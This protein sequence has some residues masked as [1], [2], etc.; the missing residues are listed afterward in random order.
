[1]I[2]TQPGRRAIQ[3][4]EQR[5]SISAGASAVRVG[6]LAPAGPRPSSPRQQLRQQLRAVLGVQDHHGPAEAGA[7]LRARWGG[8]PWRVLAAGGVPV[9]E[10]TTAQIT[11]EYQGHG[12]KDLS[13]TTLLGFATRSP[14]GIFVNQDFGARQVTETLAHELWHL[15]AGGGESEV[16]CDLFATMFLATS[17]PELSHARLQ[18]LAAEQRELEAAIASV[19]LVP[20]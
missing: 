10:C 13:G 7:D 17:F 16:H 11:R 8:N 18:Q 15:L 14:L 12:N 3:G 1:M 6:R 4:G 2:S 9:T 19:R 5:L 20:R